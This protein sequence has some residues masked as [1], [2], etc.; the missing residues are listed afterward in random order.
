[1]K[2]S[3]EGKKRIELSRKY[4]I[5]PDTFKCDL[6]LLFEEGYSSSE[7]IFLMQHVEIEHGDKTL[8]NTIR[9]YYYLWKKL[10]K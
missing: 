10:Q 4:G 8:R 1:M 2:I 5:R 9:K 6:F 3:K 7:A